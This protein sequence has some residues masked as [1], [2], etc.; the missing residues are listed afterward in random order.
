MGIKNS[1][2]SLTLL[3]DHQ[4][5]ATPTAWRIRDTV[6]SELVAAGDYSFYVRA[7]YNVLTLTYLI[8]VHDSKF[9]LPCLQML[10][11][12][13]KLDTRFKLPAELKIYIYMCL[14]VSI[15]TPVLIRGYSR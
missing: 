3:M 15:Y 9:Q 12:P 6:T 2:S 11:S 13:L 8:A 4:Q 1:P 14:Y 5:G 7:D 10:S